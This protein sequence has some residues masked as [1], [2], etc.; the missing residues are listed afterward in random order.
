METRVGRAFQLSH[1]LAGQPPVSLPVARVMPKFQGSAC[2]FFERF[3]ERNGGDD[4]WSGKERL[5]LKEEIILLVEDNLD[6]AVMVQALLDYHGLGRHVE[7]VQGV[8]EA[9][10]YLLGRWPYDEAT[11]YPRPTLIILDHWLNDGTGL[12]LLEWV[13]ERLELRNIPIIL[14]TGCRDPEVRDR[15]LAL[16]VHEFLIK[17]EGFEA[18]GLAIERLVRP[19]SPGRSNGDPPSQDTEK[20]G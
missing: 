3:G 18:L 15:A 6:H 14:F 11:R 12:D 9:K 10:A 7:V 17:P 1:R 19:K 8:G 4:G 5:E 16:G 13:S 20:A 2:R